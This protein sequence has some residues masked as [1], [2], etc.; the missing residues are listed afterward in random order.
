MNLRV[1]PSDDE[2]EKISLLANMIA[3]YKNPHMFPFDDV[4]RMPEAERLA[5]IQT[6]EDMM[7]EM[8]H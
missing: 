2:F 5:E 7:E 1:M 3:V 4:Y 6:L 8:M